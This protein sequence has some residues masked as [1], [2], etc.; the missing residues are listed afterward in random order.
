MIDEESDE[1]NDDAQNRYLK[2]LPSL[3]ISGMT[4]VLRMFSGVSVILSD[5]K[6]SDSIEGAKVSF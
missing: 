1:E 6:P 2:K 3:E 4:L 5:V